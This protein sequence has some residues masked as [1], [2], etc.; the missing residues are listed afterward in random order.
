MLA[1]DI[2]AEDCLRGWVDGVASSG[3]FVKNSEA[4]WYVTGDN[5][6]PEGWTIEKAES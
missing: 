2:S 5:G 4:T 1:T 3:T 6:I